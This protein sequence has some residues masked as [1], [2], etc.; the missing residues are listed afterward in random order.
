MLCPDWQTYSGTEQQ[1]V[2]DMQCMT[3]TAFIMTAEQA[4]KH[5]CSYCIK[6]CNAGNKLAPCH[7]LL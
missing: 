7:Q 5:R 4:S 2:N 1:T 6:D 3:H